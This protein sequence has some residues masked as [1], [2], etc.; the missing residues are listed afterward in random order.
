M[1]THE[2]TLQEVAKPVSA[3]KIIDSV[4]RKCLIARYVGQKYAVQVEASVY[5]WMGTLCGQYFGADWHHYE[6]SNGAFYLAPNLQD[7]LQIKVATKTYFFGDLSCDAAGILATLCALAAQ[8]RLTGDN[9]FEA[10][11]D[12]LYLYATTHEEWPA[13]RLAIDI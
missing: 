3:T 9:K 13:L 4:E 7:P 10:L 8:A 2:R 6:L 12:R 11:R 5:S 1:G